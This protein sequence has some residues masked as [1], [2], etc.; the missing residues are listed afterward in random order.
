MKVVDDWTVDGKAPSEIMEELRRQWPEINV[1]IRDIYNARKKVK[2]LHKARAS[3]SETDGQQVTDP[4][5]LFPGPTP[6]GKW[7]WAEAGQHLVKYSKKRDKKVAS[8]M[9]SGPIDPQLQNGNNSHYSHDSNDALL[10]GIDYDHSY[11]NAAPDAEHQLSH[12][13]TGVSDTEVA[14]GHN[15][16]FFQEHRNSFPTVSAPS[17]VG[18]VT[19]VQPLPAE[20]ATMVSPPQST[21]SSVAAATYN[22]INGSSS[23]KDSSEVPTG[24][25]V[26][27]RLEQ[28]EREQ[29]ET[30]NMISQVLSQ[31][32]KTQSG[33]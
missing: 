5:N 20:S 9:E 18:E 15:D 1:I 7:V 32:G 13:D 2:D 4:N 16:P 22:H 8:P 11:H 30:K 6:S 14:N 26:F 25:E 3:S 17:H 31:L 19:A 21:N 33:T 23:P 29:L 28:M 27:S 10:Q 12:V 24:S